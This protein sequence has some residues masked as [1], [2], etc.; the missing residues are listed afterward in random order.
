MTS[1]ASERSTP[2][3]PAIRGSKKQP[4][5]K[6]PTSCDEECVWYHDIKWAKFVSSTDANAEGHLEDGKVTLILSS[7]KKVEFK[8]ESLGQLQEVIRELENS[9]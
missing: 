3:A 1:E 4:L 7:G 2:P 6:S 5:E 8:L 9:I